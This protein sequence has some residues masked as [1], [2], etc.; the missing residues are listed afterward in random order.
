MK[1]EQEKMIELLEDLRFESEGDFSDKYGGRSK[2]EVENLF[3]ENILG[4]SA[5]H[6]PLSDSEMNAILE[7]NAGAYVRAAKTV[8]KYAMS[9]AR[10]GVRNA[11]VGA[12]AGMKAARHHVANHSGKYAAVATPA[13][14]IGGNAAKDRLN[15][16]NESVE[17]LAEGEMSAIH[18]EVKDNLPHGHVVGGLVL[19]KSGP[20][21]AVVSS[22]HKLFP[23]FKKYHHLR[24]DKSGGWEYSFASDQLKEGWGGKAAL[25]GAGFVAG[26]GAENAASNYLDR[27]YDRDLYA[28]RVRKEKRQK[29][30]HH[31]SEGVVKDSAT[32]GAITGAALGA[33]SGKLRG[34]SP[35]KSSIGGA[36]SG[37]AAGA[38]SGYVG[39]KVFAKNKKDATKNSV[40][41]TAKGGALAHGINGAISGSILGAAGEHLRYRSIGRGGV[42]GAAIGGATGVAYGAGRGALNAYLGKKVT[43]ESLV[44]D[45]KYEYHYAKRYGAKKALVRRLTKP[46]RDIKKLQMDFMK[47]GA[48]AAS[49][50]AGYA[51]GTALYNSTERSGNRLD[52]FSPIV[53][54]RY[55]SRV[56]QAAKRKY[57]A[58]PGP[59]RK[60]G[61]KKAPSRMMRS[62]GA[63]IGATLGSVAGGVLGGAVG[64]P[65]GAA[66]GSMA[67]AGVGAHIGQKSE[68]GPKAKTGSAVT[69]A[70]VGGA[71][72]GPIGAGVGGYVGKKLG[73]G[74]MTKAIVG[75]ALAQGAAGAGLGYLYTRKAGKKAGAAGAFVGGGVGAVSGALHGAMVGAGMKAVHALSHEERK[76]KANPGG[77]ATAHHHHHTK[78]KTT[79]TNESTSRDPRSDKGLA[80][81]ESKWTRA[82]RVALGAGLGGLIA[83]RKGAAVGAGLGLAGTAYRNSRSGRRNVYVSDRAIGAMT[84]KEKELDRHS[85]RI[86]NNESSV[87]PAPTTADSALA[88]SVFGSV[89]HG[90]VTGATAGLAAGAKTGRR[91]GVKAGVIGAGIGAALGAGEGVIDGAVTS[92]GARKIA[93]ARNHVVH[94]TE[95]SNGVLGEAVNTMDVYRRIDAYKKLGFRVYDVKVNDSYAEFTC[96]DRDGDISR[97]IFDGKGRRVENLGSKYVEKDNGGDEDTAGATTT[98]AKKRRGRP[99]GKTKAKYTH[100]VKK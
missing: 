82:G 18:A 93:K 19:H 26:V 57:A 21:Y 15:R 87:R 53:G 95:E 34:V 90:L 61:L 8:G 10:H 2:N 20:N 94:T 98:T 86:I 68:K 85:K 84:A 72:G 48:L 63:G 17:H 77:G 62:E 74:T 99:P 43:S 12:R 80:P 16:N 47:A 66:A 60:L 88:G 5:S 6:D 27:K 32:G 39:K 36:I 81:R 4:E 97:H 51:V 65:V 40:I 92:W 58:M 41:N 29:Q 3:R 42:I 83:G 25:A 45:A 35:F 89:S 30:H 67:G 14:L 64:G 76:R 9:Q 44:G 33:L 38:I 73:E 69:G 71:V 55:V 22:H 56:A 28:K 79:T 7:F 52:E 59:M 49:G 100:K 24:R 23:V 91:F 50:V 31:V 70:L 78:H 11:M 46:H 54:A 37:A 75:G 1:L 96:Q 13:V